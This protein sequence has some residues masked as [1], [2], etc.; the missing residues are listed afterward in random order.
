MKPLALFFLLAP[1]AFAATTP[2]P[3]TAPYFP[4]LLQDKKGNEWY[5]EQ[6]GGLQRNGSQPTLVGNA[7]LLQIG[8]QQFYSQQP[9]ASP[10]GREI[11]MA[12]PQ[13]MNGVSVSRS[14]RFLEKDGALRYIEQFT[15]AT[16]RDIT[17]SIEIRQGFNNPVKG[18]ISNTGREI[19]DA[20]KE[21]EFGIAALPSPNEKGT[22]ALL[23]SIRAGNT[24]LQPRVS[25]R[26][27]YQLS[28]FYNFL[29]PAGQSAI[30]VHAIAQAKISPTA[31]PE[32]IAKAFQP[33]T[34]AHLTKDMPRSALK[35]AVNLQGAGR[36]YGLDDWFPARYWNVAPESSDILV[37]DG[38]SR[39]NG[40]ATGTRAALTGTFGR[41][42]AFWDQIAALAGQGF[43]GTQQS[44]LWLRD[45]Q[46]WLGT[47]DATGLKFTL[48]S[49]AELELSQINRLV[50]S[51]PPAP[52]AKT[53]ATF[54]YLL[55]TWSGERLAFDPSEN[56]KADT[57]WGPVSVP[58]TDVVTVSAAGSEALGGMLVL[59]DGTRIR[60]LPAHGIVTLH[61][62]NF[63]P[64]PFDLSQMRQAITPLAA[65]GSEE[66]NEPASSFLDLI[67]Q[68]RL[69]ARV[70]N[71]SLHFLTRGAPV[72]LTPANIR[73]L[74]QT[75]R[76]DSSS[77]ATA[78]LPPLFKAEL[79]GGGSIVGS[80]EETML[81]VEGRGF[82]WELPVRQVTRMAN[83]VPVTDS[84][85]LR[86]I[87]GLIQELG[88]AKWQ[89]REG[90]S[91]QLREMGIL[92]KTSLKEALKQSTDAEVTRRLEAL[93]ADLE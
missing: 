35:L 60:M 57:P 84:A 68:Q 2:P 10:D 54:S 16:N 36:D 62:R 49:G 37:L 92:A 66:E 50:L 85:L 39:V 8:N 6:N 32:E 3:P 74:T 80:L 51:L 69:V 70:T 43:T 13:P 56:L 87:G 28:A 12:T 53:T 17:V 77:E 88:D 48:I 22:P 42:E 40:H 41:A 64:Q 67:G 86:R 52:D 9:M 1:T 4:T 47:L 7:M 89:T 29:I 59:Q 20:L 14:I 75:E 44:W 76:D 34:L 61:T 55:E 18:F 11:T 65:K 82:A 73:E 23:F 27:S 26:N 79:W 90:A 33:I 31:K 72:K 21:D 58:W 24:A 15:N 71:A 91:R 78:N 83:P 63:G 19:K 93:L 5:I 46:R 81:A 45:G 30:V 25:M 38:A